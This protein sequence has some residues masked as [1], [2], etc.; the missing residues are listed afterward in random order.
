MNLK[1][2]H[3]N[4][5]LHEAI[6]N[7]IGFRSQ[8]SLW[9]ADHW[10]KGTQMQ[11]ILKYIFLYVC[12]RD[13]NQK[14]IFNRCII[15]GVATHFMFVSVQ[16]S[17][18]V[19]LANETQ[20]MNWFMIFFC[21]FFSSHLFPFRS[22]FF[23]W[24]SRRRKKKRISNNSIFCPA[25]VFTY[26]I[27]KSHH[28]M[29]VRAYGTWVCLCFALFS[30]SLVFSLFLLIFILCVCVSKMHIVLADWKQWIELQRQ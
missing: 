22:S 27:L 26:S 10:N 11:F 25:D 13:N 18:L 21:D 19:F 20:I 1:I 2:K 14:Y 29:R 28:L 8:N 9:N 30:L 4:H 3:E 17:I 5:H 12:I 23:T 24:K 7:V 6:G 15:V 16:F